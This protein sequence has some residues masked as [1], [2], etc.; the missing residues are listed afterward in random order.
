MGPTPGDP[1][2]P[3]LHLAALVA[4]AAGAVVWLAATRR[5]ERPT[6]RQWW[7]AAGAL[8]SLVAAV[9]WPVADV[10]ARWALTG[11]V[12]QRLLLTLVAAPLLLVATPPAVL[13]AV[14]R[15]AP[16]DAAVELLTRPLVAVAVFTVV[17][18]GTLLPPVVQAQAT[19]GA[20]RAGLDVLL[21]AA[22]LVLWGPIVRT[23]PGASRVGPLG[24]A[25]YCIVQSLVPTFLAVVFVF[26]RHPFY[27][28]YAHAA[29]AVGISP[30]ADQQVAGILGKVGTLPVLWTVAWREIG[31]ARRLDEAGEDPRPLLWADVQRR[32]ERAER[33]PPPGEDAGRRRHPRQE[34]RPQL[35]T[36][37]PTVEPPGPEGSGDGG[38]GPAG[39]A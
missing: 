31:R 6:P 34:W 21:L 3:H 16:L 38:D 39:G 27:P 24:T 13:A 9:S 33:R 8:V 19:S 26:A 25:V 37:F 23:L 5:W 12:G 17:A 14:T 10:A 29:G 18:V 7:L 22:G 32:L 35:T 1:W 4:V 15:P 20:A 28:V 36:S 30:L 2:T 11:L